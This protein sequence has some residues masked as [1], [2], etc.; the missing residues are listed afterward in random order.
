MEVEEYDNNELLEDLYIEEIQGSTRRNI[1]SDILVNGIPISFK[2][3][4]GAE[5]NV[6]SLG[7]ANELNAQVQPTSMLLK[8]FGGHQLDTVGKCLLDTRVK[9]VKGSTPL[10]FYVL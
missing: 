3:Y 9:E 1:Q 10:E 4:T 2:L 8:S 5:C 7:L 6:I